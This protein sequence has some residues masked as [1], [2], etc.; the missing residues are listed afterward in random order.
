M[1]VETAD[2]NM[3]HL[4]PPFR[5]LVQQVLDEANRELYN[6][7]S[8]PKFPSVTLYAMFEGYRSSARQQWLFDQHRAPRPVPDHHGYGL[9]A[10]IVW[11][12]NAGNPHWDDQPAEVW[13]ILGHC[14][15]AAGLEW[16]GD[17]PNPDLVH[18]QP[19]LAQFNAMIG[20]ARDYIHSLGLTTPS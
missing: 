1:G 5:A 17:W 9:A 10:D 3:N 2:N 14:A 20:P 7:D 13:Q 6:P 15:R 8:T 16:G 12:D 19:P 11:Y 4:Y 18:I